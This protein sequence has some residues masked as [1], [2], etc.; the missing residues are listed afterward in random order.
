MAEKY[1]DDIRN[2]AHLAMVVTIAIFSSVIIV[3]NIL[4]GWEKWTIPV[5][6]VAIPVT[7]VMHITH[8]PQEN[9]RIYIY[10]AI[11]LL[12]LFYYSVLID[13]LY[14]A[15]PVVVLMLFLF[16]MTQEKI[17]SVLCLIT[18]YFGMIFH[19]VL[20]HNTVGL[21]MGVSRTA[22][23][24]WHFIIVIIAYYIADRLFSAILRMRDEFEKKVSELESVNQSAGDFLANVSHE[25]RTPIN[26][27]MGITGVCLEKDI[28]DEFKDDLML[29]EEA[30]R[31]VSEQIS[32][33]LDYSEIDMGK[34]AVNI[35]DYMLSSV[36][37]DLVTQIKPTKPADL[38]LVIDVS[39]EL[40]SVMRTDVSKLKKILWHLITNGLKYTKEGGV[41]VHIFPRTEKYGINLCIEVVD[42]GIGMDEI[43]LERITERFYQANSSRTRSSNGLG[44]GMPIVSGFVSSLGGF[45]TIE[46]KPNEGTKVRVSLPQQVISPA[47]CMSVANRERLSLGAF[48]HFEKFPNPNVREFYN[49]MLKDIVSGLKV[50]MHKVETVEN[51]KK[52]RDNMKL[53]H[54][55][56]GEEEYE[57]D[58]PFMEE[59]AKETLVIVVANDEFVPP[60][61]SNVLVMG[62]PFYCFPVVSVL[63]MDINSVRHSAE[64]M[65]CEGV[66]ALVV[67]DEPMNLNVA[68]GIF[69]RYGMEVTTALSGPD[70][71]KLCTEN[72]YDIV[73]MDHMMPGMDGVETMKNIRINAGKCRRDVPVVALTANA[74]SSAREMFMREGFD[75]FVS[76]PVERVELERVL[77]AV[78]PKEM[79]RMVP[80][81]AGTE[82]TKT[83]GKYIKRPV[84]NMEVLEGKASGP[85]GSFERSLIDQEKGLHYS[86]DDPELYKTLLIN[87]ANGFKQKSE[88][89]GMFKDSGDLK[90]YAVIVHALK[91]TSRLIGANSLSEKAKALEDAAKENDVKY[92]TE[93]HQKVMDEYEKLSGMILKVIDISD[94]DKG[95]DNEIMEFM[96]D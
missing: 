57:S 15:T 46:S 84:G 89:S 79:V 38:E 45:M 87:F 20:V 64:K 96:P 42:T 1:N 47:E 66:R 21:T 27:V 3:L 61:G 78:L 88:E 82:K 18:G 68:L 74:V 51:L 4:L 19:L 77:K 2:I 16:T 7:L 52:L 9:V 30:G 32:D 59:L 34:L 63:N 90:N 13:Q 44:L 95:E 69:R 49:A 6:L 40:P 36:L 35:E 43:Q 50:Q 56:V 8:R 72:E 31:R 60:D 14:D 93:N 33:I 81:E 58:I 25:I 73:F 67:D 71:L 76:K 65:L 37:N 17:L 39:P 23:T 26:A 62:K 22:R 86:Q 29:V 12:E 70:A 53:T 41:Y 5:F 28:D 85:L 80:I 75:G 54:L 10:T 11:L 92:I 24:A 48:L 91:S 83:A 55:F 94:K